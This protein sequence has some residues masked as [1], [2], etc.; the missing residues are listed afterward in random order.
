[1]QKLVP[2]IYTKNYLEETL[3]KK[4]QFI[5]A[6]KKIKFLEINFKKMIQ[7]FTKKTEKHESR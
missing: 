4:P 5:Q 6:T 2:L 1:M 3:N 7:N